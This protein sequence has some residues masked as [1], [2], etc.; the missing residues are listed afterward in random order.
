METYQS[1]VDLVNLKVLPQFPEEEKQIGILLLLE[2]AASLVTLF[3]Q[4]PDLT[5]RLEEDAEKILNW[6]KNPTL[7]HKV[8]LYITVRRQCRKDNTQEQFHT[9]VNACLKAG[10]EATVQDVKTLCMAANAANRAAKLA[11]Q[12][13]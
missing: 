7:F 1:V 13:S 12:E 10:K 5:L 11:V 4:C 8:R 2:I 6:L 3:Q 9:I